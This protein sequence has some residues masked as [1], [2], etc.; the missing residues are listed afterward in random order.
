MGALAGDKRVLGEGKHV[1]LVQ[2]RGWEY[3]ERPDCGGIVAILAVTDDARL[4]LVEQYREPVARPVIELPA[5]LAGDVRGDEGEALTA[6]AHR[7]LLEETGY[8]A[9]DM[10]YLT[11]GPPSAGLSNEIITFFRAEGLRKIGRG[12]GVGHEQIKV[13]EVPLDGVATWLQEVAGGGAL[14][15][16]KVYTG[17]YFAGHTGRPAV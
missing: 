16:P 4:V 5:G 2:R 12:G 14:I 6:A 13:H 10:V 17:L 15:D 9:A 7:E 8:Q 11:E 3:A 1:R